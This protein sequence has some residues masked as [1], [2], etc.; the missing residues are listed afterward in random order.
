VPT[1]YI[2]AP[3]QEVCNKS[4][5]LGPH[6]WKGGNPP[7]GVPAVR[8]LAAWPGRGRFRALTLTG[9]SLTLAAL[10]ELRA[11]P[12]AERAAVDASGCAFRGG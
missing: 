6:P 7:D 8:E 11:A 9:M 3:P 5:R 1:L 2:A 12:V 10:Q 4:A